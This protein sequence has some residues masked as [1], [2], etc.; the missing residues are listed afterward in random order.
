MATAQSEV[1][2]V[3][4]LI[5]SVDLKDVETANANYQSLEPQCVERER[6]YKARCSVGPQFVHTIMPEDVEQL[7]SGVVVNYRERASTSCTPCT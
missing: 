3:D 7:D 2:F 5:D 1:D 6:K 4:V